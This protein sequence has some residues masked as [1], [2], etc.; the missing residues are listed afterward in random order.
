M[1]GFGVQ[2]MHVV[3]FMHP[4]F[5][6]IPHATSKEIEILA[7]GSEGMSTASGWLGASGLWM[8]PSHGLGIQDTEIIQNL[9]HS[10]LVV[11]VP[12]KHI[13]LV[14]HSSGGMVGPRDWYAAFQL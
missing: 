9:V 13:H 3:V 11:V 8:R 7:Y 5:T 6:L 14:S 2:N 1:H 4:S 10:E 12:A